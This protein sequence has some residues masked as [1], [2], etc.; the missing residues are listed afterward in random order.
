V[1][2]NALALEKQGYGTTMQD[3]CDE[4]LGRWLAETPVPPN[5]RFPNVAATL[6]DWF[7]RGCLERPAETSRRLWGQRHRFAAR[8]RKSAR[9]PAA[10][11]PA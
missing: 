6:A 4:S 2:S 1:R 11:P 8:R 3:L 10:R 7:A 9:G 5:V